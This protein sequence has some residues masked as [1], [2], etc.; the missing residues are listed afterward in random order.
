MV[1]THARGNHILLISTEDPL[2]TYPS[3]PICCNCFAVVMLLKLYFISIK[4]GILTSIFNYLP[5]YF[6]QICRF[7]QIKNLVIKLGLIIF[8][9]TL[10]YHFS[11]L[12]S[13]F[14]R[15][16]YIEALMPR[17]HRQETYRCKLKIY[18]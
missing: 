16:S 6:N 8:A 7:C 4:L 12:H 11:F 13:K 2:S 17:R 18:A 5:L 1:L 15:V 9:N 14:F 10:K 3:H